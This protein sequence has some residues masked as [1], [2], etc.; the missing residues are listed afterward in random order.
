L[1]HTE[2]LSALTFISAGLLLV[3]LSTPAQAQRMDFA[4]GF[5]A[6]TAPPASDAEGNHAPV[7]LTGGLYPS[8]SAGFVMFK[9]L[10]FQGEFAWRGGRADWRGVQPYRPMFYDF[11]AMYQPRIAKGIYFEG[12]AG[13]GG[14]STRFY[15]PTE[16]CDPFVCHNYVTVNHFM[17]HFGAG[18]KAY[19]SKKIG[20]FV[21]P[22]A[23]LYL[24]HD[25]QEFSSG[26]AVRF[27]ISLGYTFGER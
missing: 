6:M 15:T 14:M 16:I 25:N 5:N 27:G 18:I 21:R 1:K 11:N 20:L 8:F 24:I 23:H 9:N 10:G 7:S 12:L 4:V 19:P 17:G 3:S 22:E 13:I 2:L 26:R